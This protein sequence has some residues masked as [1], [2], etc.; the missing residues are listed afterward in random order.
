MPKIQYKDAKE[1]KKIRYTKMQSKDAIENNKIARCVKMLVQVNSQNL[2][3]LF[4]YQKVS[5]KLDIWNTVENF[6]N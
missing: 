2:S 6:M 1:N 3:H 5:K 4:I